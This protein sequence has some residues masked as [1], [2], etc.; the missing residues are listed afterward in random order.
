MIDRALK[1]FI[2]QLF[3]GAKLNIDCGGGGG[4][5]NTTQT[6]KQV[7]WEPTQSFMTG[8]KKY[9]YDPQTNLY[10]NNVDKNGNEIGPIGYMPAASNF[11]QQYSELSPQQ[12]ALNSHYM[13]ELA[14][15]GVLANNLYG[16]TALNM[17]NGDY[18]SR[19][20]LTQ[21]HNANTA[22][23]NAGLGS[24]SLSQAYTGDMTRGRSAQG[25][26]DPTNAMQSLLTGQPD[27]PYLSAMNQANINQALRGYGDAVQNFT[28]QVI[29]SINNDAFAA[30][31]YGS[32]RQGVAEGLA[33]QQMMRNA[34][35]LGI[36]AMDSGNRLF[37]GAYENAQG[38]KS[39]AANNL[40]NQAYGM[41]QFNAGQLQNASQFNANALNDMSKFNAGQTQQNNQFNSGSL[42]NMSQFNSTQDQNTDQFNANLDMQQQAARA[43]NALQGLNTMQQGWGVQDNLFNQQQSILSAP[44]Q[45]MRNALATYASTITPGASLGGTSTTSI[46]TYNSGAGGI[47]GGLASG[48]GLL[49]SFK[50][51]I[52]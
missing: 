41:E 48:A 31:Q 38:R 32:S 1:N 2:K 17:L 27:N 28:Q 44:E 4:S 18:D 16:N 8:G 42:N 21:N 49:S 40:N 24:A 7:P 47:L 20:G 19:Y 26:L 43:Q 29:P 50:N 52:Q 30:G 23:S 34:R 13:P 6:Q 22:L 14:N 11:F 9:N 51:L 3:C 37:G 12:Q 15:R 5:S 45:Q 39:E 36:A 25:T 33:G 46:P 35:D 10:G